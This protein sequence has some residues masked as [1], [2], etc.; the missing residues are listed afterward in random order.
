MK[1]LLPFFILSLFAFV[2]CDD[3]DDRNVPL[4]NAVMQFIDSRYP[5]ATV[6]S[7]E[8]EKNGTLEVEIRHDGKIKDV[9]FNSQSNWLYT[10]WDVR[11]ADLPQVVKG[12]V[13]GAYPDYRIDE[14]DFV[15]RETINYYAVELERGGIDL[16]IYVSPEGNILDSVT[17]DGPAKP[18]LSDAV[19]SFISE[20]YPSAVIVSYDY[21]GKGLLEVD[22]RDG[23]IEKDI[24]FDSNDN[25][26]QTDWDVPADQLPD[27]VLQVL[28]DNYP[29]YFVDSAEYVERPSNVVFYEIELERVGDVEIVVDVT[30]DGEIL[31]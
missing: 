31:R 25:W 14:A 21:D 13:S 11:V 2:A 4:N 27:A 23:N 7:S 10:S 20:N 26:V 8:F 24:Y 19:R 29:Q 28:A 12:A 3:D 6:R 18:V 15:E 9:Y 16:W 30:P 5:G 1:K 17:G 22:V